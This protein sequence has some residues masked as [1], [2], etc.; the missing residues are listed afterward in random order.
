MSILEASNNESQKIEDCEITG[1]GRQNV[2]W[3]PAFL[4]TESRVVQV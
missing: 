3:D 4:R 2:H 1:H